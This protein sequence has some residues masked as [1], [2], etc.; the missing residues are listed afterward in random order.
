MKAGLPGAP[1]L[2][3]FS[4]ES[5]RYAKAGSTA[6]Q[7][8]SPPQP[9]IRAPSIQLQ[10]LRGTSPA[11]HQAARSAWGRCC[12]WLGKHRTAVRGELDLLAT[13][14][15]LLPSGA[16]LCPREAR[17]PGAYLS[18]CAPTAAR[19]APPLTGSPPCLARHS[20]PPAAKETSKK[21]CTGP[22]CALQYN[23]Y[24]SHS[25]APG[26]LLEIHA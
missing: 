14:A 19:C 25:K 23:M 15:L 5:S 21:V 17:A 6:Y 4:V 22:I 26:G 10:W 2:G 8:L 11:T 12:L 3:F 7:N 13:K 16:V 9:R 24:I 18:R 1:G 20:A